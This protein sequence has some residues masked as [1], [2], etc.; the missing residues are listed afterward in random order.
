MTLLEQAVTAWPTAGTWVPVGRCIERLHLLGENYRLIVTRRP[1]H[2]QT[3]GVIA[4]TMRNRDIHWV[5][6][7]PTVAAAIKD[8]RSKYALARNTHMR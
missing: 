3:K 5:G 2:L 8:G 6:W 1:K 4:V 7:G